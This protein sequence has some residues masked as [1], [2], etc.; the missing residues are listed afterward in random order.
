MSL[1]ML[2]ASSSA[3]FSDSNIFSYAR[4]DSTRIG[5]FFSSVVT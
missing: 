5:S 2:K 1:Y 3:A 4:A